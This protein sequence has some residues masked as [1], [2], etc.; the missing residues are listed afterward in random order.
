VPKVRRQ[1]WEKAL[2]VFTLSVPG[3]QPP[4]GECVAEV[5]K[6]RLIVKAVCAFDSCFVP[7]PFEGK[8]CR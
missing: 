1:V 3:D 5:V 7:D 8:L 4:H 2:H 6:P